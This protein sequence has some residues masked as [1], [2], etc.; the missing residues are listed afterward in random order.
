[1]KKAV[2]SIYVMVGDLLVN[3]N[4]ESKDPAQL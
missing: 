3:I 2:I 4:E 1:M